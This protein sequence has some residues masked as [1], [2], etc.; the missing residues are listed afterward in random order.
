MVYFKGCNVGSRV[1]FPFEQV[2]YSS[3]KTY[4]QPKILLGARHLGATIISTSGDDVITSFFYGWAAQYPLV[5]RLH[6]LMG[7]QNWL[8]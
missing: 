6:L 2:W 7:W 3:L 8:Q 5:F 4:C 1:E